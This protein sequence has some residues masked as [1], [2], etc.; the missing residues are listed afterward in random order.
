MSGTCDWLCCNW[1]QSHI[2]LTICWILRG[3]FVQSCITHLSTPALCLQAAHAVPQCI[4]LTSLEPS[5]TAAMLR[6]HATVCAATAPFD[7]C[8][9]PTL[10]LS[11]CVLIYLEPSE[12]EA[13]LSTAAAMAAEAGAAAAVA[14]YEQTR[15]DDAFGSTM[16]SNLEVCGL[17][18][19]GHRCGVLSRWRGSDYKGAMIVTRGG[20]GG[21]GFGLP[22]VRY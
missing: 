14:I 1:W 17:G 21:C 20:R 22:A 18:G 12:A 16:I 19:G 15:P 10:Y 3:W 7:A 11:E 6:H 2:V 9:L 13:V 4:R 5:N 8:R